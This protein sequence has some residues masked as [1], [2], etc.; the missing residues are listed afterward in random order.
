MEQ[1]QFKVLEYEGPL[2]LILSLIAKHKLNILDIE[3]GK[4]LEQYLLEIDNMKGNRLDVASEFL[5][6]ASRL[7]YIKSKMLLPRQEEEA[8]PREDLT[9]ALLEYQTCKHAAELLRE[10]DQ[11]GE[12]FVREPMKLPAD[13]AYT[14]VHRP[15]ELLRAYLEALG[16]GKRRLPPPKTAFHGIVAHRVVSVASRISYVMNWLYRGG[17]IRLVQIYGGC[18]DRSERVATFLAILELIKNRRVLADDAGSQ[19]ML[20][21][22]GSEW[23]SKMVINE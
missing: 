10:R 18:S 20:L 16:R 9:G 14:L 8:D 21:R 1:L 3:I 7:V 17:W 23:L 4:L 22:S 11:T 5:E 13:P 6:M 19:V 2:D 15:Q 12:R